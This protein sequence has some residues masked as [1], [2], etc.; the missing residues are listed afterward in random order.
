MLKW[1]EIPECP[2]VLQ[3]GG[4]KDILYSKL[5]GRHIA[6]N[7]FFGTSNEMIHSFLGGRK[8]RYAFLYLSFVR[9]WSFYCWKILANCFPATPHL[10]LSDKF[11]SAMRQCLAPA[12]S[13]VVMMPQLEVPAAKLNNK[14][15]NRF[16][17]MS[18]GQLNFFLIF[19]S[20]VRKNRVKLGCSLEMPQLH[21]NSFKFPYNWLYSVVGQR[22]HL[23]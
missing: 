17:Q 22:V 5:G 16:S 13:C 9:S 6:P 8:S 21:L 3:L 20:E 11:Q 19:S 10:S 7:R 14:L 15:S 1:M 23:L 4:W 2:L 18:A 12:P